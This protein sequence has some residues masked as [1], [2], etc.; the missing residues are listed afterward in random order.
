MREEVGGH[1]Q[2]GAEVQPSPE[3]DDQEA[4]VVAEIGQKRQRFDLA[5]REG[6]S[7][8]GRP[9][10]PGEPPG[11]ADGQQVGDVLERHAAEVIRLLIDAFPA[12]H[13]DAEPR[14]TRLFHASMAD[15]GATVRQVLSG[16]KARHTIAQTLQRKMLEAE[17]AMR[18]ALDERADS[19]RRD[20]RTREEC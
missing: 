19:G 17:A 12:S 18:E 2:K 13:P 3:E 14:I 4:R 16:A 11:G 9:A 20:L 8:A 6:V 1:R 5:M 7:G 10:E 15:V